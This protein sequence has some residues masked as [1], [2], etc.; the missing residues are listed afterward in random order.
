VSELFAPDQR[1]SHLVSLVVVDLLFGVALFVGAMTALWFAWSL[2][3]RARR[4]SAET[5]HYPAL[6]AG[7]MLLC[8]TA[9]RA[10]GATP[11]GAFVELTITQAG[12][13]RGERD[14]YVEWTEVSRTLVEH[15]FLL[16]T[17]EGS[18]VL[19][20]TDPFVD[21]V[22]RLQQTWRI[23]PTMRTRTACV[24]EGEQLWVEGELRSEYDRA[25]SDP[26]RGATK[27]RWIIEAPRS[28]RLL[29]TSKPVGA[30]LRRA[31]LLSAG[32]ALALIGLLCFFQLVVFADF[33]ALRA[34]G[35]VTQATITSRQDWQSH[36]K[37]DSRHHFEWIVEYDTPSGPRRAREEVSDKA[38]QAHP[39]GDRV[40]VTYL[41]VRPEVMQIGPLSEVGVDSY[42]IWGTLT[43][44]GLALIVINWRRTVSRKLKWSRRDKLV[45]RVPGDLTRTK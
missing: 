45:E 13:E 4:L 18:E 41:S 22:D 7:H 10:Q 27:L 5:W 8:G 32:G 25:S 2:W 26:Y 40:P 36:S 28:G 16:R 44:A 3:S 34:H 19:V 33:R 39:P 1:L 21:L 11:T 35:V 23:G 30:D 31:S 6:R 38:Y 20:R 29:V 24:D 12:V 42:S 9:H 43:I 15:P 17:H 37:G 14:R